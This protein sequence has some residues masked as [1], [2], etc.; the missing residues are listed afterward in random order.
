[1][2]KTIEN[3]DYTAPQMAFVPVNSAA[4]ILIGSPTSGSEEFTEGDNLNDL[5]N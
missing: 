3:R 1:M 4:D 5:F 2:K